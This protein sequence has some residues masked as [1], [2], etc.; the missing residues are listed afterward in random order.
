MKKPLIKIVASLLKPDTPAWPCINQDSEKELSRIL[1]PVIALNPDMEFDVA[2][3]Y[4]PDE[5]KADYEQDLKKYDGVLLLRM[6]STSR[7]LDKLYV[8]RCKDGLP[9]IIADIPYYAGHPI[10]RLLPEIREK[11]L[12]IPLISTSDYTEI[13]RAVKLF[14]VM[15]KMKQTTVLVITENPEVYKMCETFKKDWGCSF[16]FKPC[17]DVNEYMKK[18]DVT[19]A[20]RIADKWQNEATEVLEAS[21]DDILESAKLHLSLKQMMN[22]YK[23]DAVTIDCLTLS[24]GGS[25]DKNTHMYPCLS[26]YEMLNNGTV[27]V[28]EADPS[29]TVTS[30]IL[31]YLADRPGYVSDPVVDTSCNQIIYAHCVSCT[32]VFGCNDPRRC[33]YAIRSHSEDKKGA[34]VQ[35]F[36][37]AGEALTTTMVYPSDLYSTVIHSSTSV[38]NVGFQEGCRSKLAATANA[39]AIFNNWSGTWHRVTVFGDYRKQL[40]NLYKLKGLSVIEEDK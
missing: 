11:N 7:P 1:E 25:Y 36:F 33:S 31:K 4:G 28:C 19:E 2:R 23:A 3:Y 14:G 22:D 40:M 20:E 27:A 18:V 34:S 12:P 39:E 5:A 16:I 15:A 24:Y 9:L 8:E 21:G 35:T 32:K 26:H 6:C 30:L 38:G 17:A 29:A 37:P 10:L 13:A